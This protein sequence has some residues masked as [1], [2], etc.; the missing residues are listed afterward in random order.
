MN[1]LECGVSE[2]IKEA[3]HTIARDLCVVLGT[4]NAAALAY[5]LTHG[6]G[7]HWHLV[8]NAAIYLSAAY[9]EHGHVEH[10]RKARGG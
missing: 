3:M 4:Y 9:W 8:V 2:E 1:A 6:R 10:H 7:G 5:R